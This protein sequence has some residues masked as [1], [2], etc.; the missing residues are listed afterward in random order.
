MHGV[1]V[2]DAGFTGSGRL[3]V[4]SCPAGAATLAP[5]TSATCTAT[6]TVTQ[7]DLDSGSISNAATAS[8]H[9]PAGG[10]ITSNRSSAMVVSKPLSKLGLTKSAHAV[11]VNRDGVIDRGDR[12]DWTLVATN[13]GATT[14]TD[15]VV[16][17][18]SAGKPQCPKTTLAP[19]ASM[20]CAV[21]SHTVTASDVAR[22]QFGNVAFAHGTV[23]GT[24]QISTPPARA[25]A[26]VHSTLAAVVVRSHGHSPLPFTGFAPTLGLT[27]DAIIALLVGGLLLSISLPRRRQVFTLPTTPAGKG[28]PGWAR[29]LV[30]VGY[31]FVTSRNVPAGWRL[32]SRE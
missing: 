24:T 14:I 30:G 2:H 7:A 6:Y 3:S 21:R 4:V 22:G 18:R 32:A 26:K 15:I 12:I 16:V 11:D 17:D 8:A 31:R 20:T 27:R 13:L 25:T 29:R 9:D 1:T 5:S 23:M 28:W 19:S 10:K